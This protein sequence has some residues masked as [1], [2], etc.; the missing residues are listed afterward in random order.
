MTVIDSKTL[1]DR[2]MKKTFI[3]ILVVLAVFVSAYYLSNATPVVVA[4]LPAT[5][6]NTTTNFPATAALAYNPADNQWTITHSSLQQTTD[7]CI[8]FFGTLQATTNNATQLY[9]WYPTTTNAATEIVYSGTITL[10]N[11]TYPQVITTNSQQVYI[12][13]GQ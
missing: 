2:N 11:Y 10:T 3:A 5:V 6:N 12:S 4:G 7:I 13:H 1:S 9:T 8:K